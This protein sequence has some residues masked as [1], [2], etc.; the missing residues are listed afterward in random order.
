VALVPL[1]ITTSLAFFT[2]V[3]AIGGLLFQAKANKYE[4]LLEKCLILHGIKKLNN[5]I[6][7]FS[8]PYK[9]PLI[10]IGTVVEIFIKD[11]NIEKKLGTGVVNF[12]QTDGKTLHVKLRDNKIAS[13]IKSEFFALPK[14]EE[15][16]DENIS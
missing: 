1:G 13:L 12:I 6:L 11:K 5:E 8:A 3:T 2:L 15:V 10:K 14:F 4:K 9:S 16:K 7:I